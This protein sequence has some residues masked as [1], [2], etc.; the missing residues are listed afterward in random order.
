MDL[1]KVRVSQSPIEGVGVFAYVDFTA[2]ESVL[3]IDDSRVVDANHP[4]P[5]EEKIYQDF[6]SS[7]GVV[8]MQQPERHINHSCDPNVFVRTNKGVREVIAIRLIH[9]GEEIVLDY[10]INGYDDTVWNCECLSSRCRRAVHSDFF[11]LP[12]AVQFEYL[13][14]LDHW[15]RVEFAD[16]LRALDPANSSSQFDQ[17]R[18][19]A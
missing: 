6:L 13:P 17:K 9:A 15:Y 14:L 5:K 16:Q 11:H 7:G 19:S 4:V 12:M 10:S 18:H 8:L 2:G 3:S 1:N